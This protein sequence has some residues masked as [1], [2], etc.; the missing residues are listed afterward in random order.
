[1][2]RRPRIAT[3]CA[4]TVVALAALAAVGLDREERK[5]GDPSGVQRPAT[6]VRVGL[7]ANTL[8]AG[9]RMGVELDLAR[10]LPARWLREEFR[11]YEVE[12]R[13]GVLRWG[14]LDRLMTEASRRGLRVLPLL[15]G[16]PGWVSSSKMH[17]PHQTGGFARFTAR[18]ARRYGPGGTFWRRRPQAERRLAPQV[19]E[20]WNEPFVPQFADGKVDPRRYARL[21]RAAARAGARA[22][23]HTRYLLD[24]ETTYMTATGETREWIP[25]LLRAVPDLRRWVWGLAVHPYSITQPPSVYTPDASRFQF[26]R[27][28]EVRR[29][30]GASPRLWLTELGWSTCPSGTDC[31]TEGDQARYLREAF[32]IARTE[33]LNVEAIFVYRLRDFGPPMPHDR[34]R[35]FGLRRADGS[36]K[37]GW[38][39]LRRIAEEAP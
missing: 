8:D 20:V 1:M 2:M 33:P 21:F 38:S 12:P 17:L 32:D 39:A 7:I 15:I 16:S 37:P 19:L 23:P 6:H 35:W 31:V 5:Q 29:A 36:A 9:S 14:K 27:I 34:E 24:V 3:L 30:W 10:R 18:V 28:R 22:N 11:W 13:P 25:D 4:T 26:L